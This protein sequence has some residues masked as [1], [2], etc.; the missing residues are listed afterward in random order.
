LCFSQCRELVQGLA[1]EG[2]LL[3]TMANHHYTDFALNWVYHAKAANITGYL[4]AALDD[5]LLL[6]LAR[7][8]VNT[9]SLSTGEARSLI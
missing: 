9:F 6:S 1:Q 8:K 7:Q 4:V 2:M 3:V 5:Q